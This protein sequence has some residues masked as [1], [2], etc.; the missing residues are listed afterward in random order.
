MCNTLT[1]EGLM[2]SMWFK[3]PHFM[4]EKRE[5]QWLN[6]IQRS[7]SQNMMGIGPKPETSVSR[8][9]HL[10]LPHIFLNSSAL[11]P[12]QQIASKREF[13]KKMKSFT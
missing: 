4:N 10:P 11:R 5:A 12:N 7:Q 8:T 6:G 13:W 2:Q 1:L 3:P 9:L